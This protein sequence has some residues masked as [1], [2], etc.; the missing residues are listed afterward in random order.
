MESLL[1]KKWIFTAR[2]FLAFTVLLYSLET[3]AFTEH[4]DSYSKSSASKYRTLKPL[5]S[6]SVM[7]ATAQ[8]AHTSQNTINGLVANRL[9]I[10]R[11][12]DGRRGISGE[13]SIPL[14]HS[15]LNDAHLWSK[16][17]KT[18][19]RQQDVGSISG[20]KNTVLG[21]MVGI[22]GRL[23]KTLVGLAGSYA[24]T[25]VKISDGVSAIN[26]NGYQVTFYGLRELSPS[27]Y[28]DGHLSVA[29]NHY[30]SSRELG[31]D[32][33][34]HSV[35]SNYHG[36][37]GAVQLGGGY[38]MAHH[39]WNMVPHAA[40]R[41]SI[42]HVKKYTETNANGLTSPNEAQYNK[43]LVSDLGIKLNRPSR[44]NGHLVTPEFRIG[45]LRDF[46]AD[47]S[48]INANFTDGSPSFIIQG[49]RP[50][51][52]TFNIGAGLGLAGTGR[53]RIL[54]DYDIELKKG[55]MSQNLSLSGKMRFN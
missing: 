48:K 38:K 17:F 43:A 33:I 54:A 42:M 2:G 45:Y 13:K 22:D 41:Y 53:W 11:G 7:R 8:G 52:S 34:G 36:N 39:G 31:F 25:N 28:M 18:F 50:H 40:G 6:Q 9:A 21:A 30:K 5:I 1:S 55:Y 24:S 20:Y 12:I 35:Q 3:Q 37:Q 27:F 51:R 46:I 23:S 47:T 26:I 10:L 16:G 29:L 44:F 15:P 4:E 14:K 49:L 32:T 19:A